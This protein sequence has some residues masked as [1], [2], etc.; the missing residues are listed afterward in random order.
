MKICR[1]VFTYTTKQWRDLTNPV[2]SVMDQLNEAIATGS[3]T[4]N[5]ISIQ[6]K[7][8][9]LEVR[10]DEWDKWYSPRMCTLTVFYRVEEG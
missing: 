3:I 10:R 2:E 6:E 4:E 8:E 9:T 5:I 1:K 7:Q